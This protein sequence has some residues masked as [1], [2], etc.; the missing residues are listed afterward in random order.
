[1]KRILSLLICCSLVLTSCASNRRS[2]SNDSKGTRDSLQYLDFSSSYSDSDVADSFSSVNGELLTYMEDTVYYDLV[3]DLDSSDY[4][5]ENVQAMYV[6]QEYI[7]ELTYNS[8]ENIYFGYHLSDIKEA[9]G[10]T[11]WFFTVD[12]TGHTVVT[13]YTYK[14]FEFNFIGMLR[15]I[16]IGTGVILICATVA[17]V[18]AET[19]PAVSMIMMVSA[20][21]ATAFALTSGALGATSS[22]LVTYIQTGDI[23]QSLQAA[24]D[25][26]GKG[27]KIGAITGA[28]MGAGK[29]I[30]FLNKAT[31]TKYLT[32][33]Q[34]ARIQRESKYPAELIA[35]I[36]TMEEY[37]VLTKA[38][39]EPYLV[40]NKTAL[41]PKDIDWNTEYEGM[42]NLQRIANGKAPIDPT[43]GVRYDLHHL[44]Q[45]AD[46]TLALIPSSLHQQNTKILHQFKE[47]SEVD[48]GSPWEKQKREFYKN[49]YNL[50][51]KQ[52]GI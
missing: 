11:P 45:E 32:W 4:Y 42:T 51:S 17:L 48:H 5:V 28:V 14:D 1:M 31:S 39:L 30:A 40:G 19:L 9:F 49:L 47:I 6:S 10:D 25:G 46:G 22:G 52:L 37:E 24:M 18:T 33:N 12:E 35:Q 3:S 2:D 43:T 44:G 20:K 34:A 38:N 26:G 7:E 21:T 29:E 16:A 36:H 27:Y 8:Q 50:V 13:E 23:N 41:L 15:D